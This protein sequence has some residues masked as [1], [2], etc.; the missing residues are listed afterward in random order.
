MQPDLNRL[1]ELFRAIEASRVGSQLAVDMALDALTTEGAAGSLTIH[2][3]RKNT[4]KVEI[5]FRLRN[6]HPDF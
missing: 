3:P 5:A 2:I 4:E 1:P 6:H